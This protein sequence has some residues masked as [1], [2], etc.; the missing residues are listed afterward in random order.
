MNNKN[1]KS[2]INATLVALV[3]S[4][5]TLALADDT[6]VFLARSS[7]PNLLFV[8]DMS[9]SMRWGIQARGYNPRTGEIDEGKPPSRSDVMKNAMKRVLNQAPDEINIGLMSYGP[10]NFDGS[11]SRIDWPE[12][13]R[14]HGVHGVGFPIKGI[15]E[16][17]L[18]IVS[19][20]L[21]IDNLPDPSNKTIVRKYLSEIIKSWEPKGST[22]IVDSLVEA[23]RYFAGDKVFFG[24][25]IP[26]SQR[27]AHPLTYAGEVITSDLVTT[28]RKLSNAPNYKS[29]ITDGCQENYIAL[30][31][32][33][34]P[35]YFYS[36]Q[37]E[38]IREKG[39]PFVV[40]KENWGKG[41]GPFADY[42]R[43]N[44]NYGTLA[45]SI[46]DCAD[47][48]SGFRAGTCGPEIARYMA[49]GDM[50]DEVSGKQTI[51]MFTVGYT[52][53]VDR[54]TQEYLKSLVTVEDNPKTPWREGYY[55]ADNAQKLKKALF[56][57]VNRVANSASTLGSPSYSVNV[58]NGLEHEDEIYIP[59]FSKASGVRWSGNLKKFGLVNTSQGGYE[60]KKIKGKN[61]LE[62][63]DEQGRFTEDALDYWSNSPTESPD[64][65]NLRAGGVAGKLNPASRKLF[66][67]IVC[68]PGSCELNSESNLLDTKNEKITSE[69]LGLKGN[70]NNKGNKKG[71]TDFDDIDRE[72]LIN[73]IRGE[74]PDN[75]I[76]YHMGDM[77][78]SDPLV[79]TYASAGNDIAKKQYIFVGTNEGYLHAFDTTTGEEK[80]AFMPKELLENIL[81][82]YLNVDGNHLY[83]IDGA[84]SHWQDKVTKKR[85]LY[86]GM[87]RGGT[88]FYALDITDIDNPRLLWKKSAIDYPSMG[89]SWS[90]PYLD[91]I[92][93]G[94][95]GDKR[96]AVIISGGYDDIEDRNN[97]KGLL[98]LDNASKD[99]KTRVGKDILIL[100]A[101]TGEKLWSL[102]DSLGNSDITDSIP[103]GIRVLDTNNNNIADRM[104]FADTGG[105][106]WRLD[107][108]EALGSRDGKS[109]LTKLASL[110]GSGSNSR[111]FYIEPEVASVK[112]RGKLLYVVSVGSG[113]RAHPLNQSI[114]DKFFMLVDDLPFQPVDENF[115]TIQTADLAQINITGDDAGDTSLSTNGS[116][117]DEGKRGWMIS[118]PQKGEKVLTKAITRN[119]SVI[120]TTFVPETDEASCGIANG[121]V[122]RLYAINVVTGKAGINFKELQSRKTL[123]KT[124]EASEE[125]SPRLPGPGYPG[126]V[127]PPE[128]VFGS[129][130]VDA[131]GVCKHP[132]DYR[133]G[134]KSS[135]VSGYSACSLEPAYWSDPEIN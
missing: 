125:W 27:G 8:I 74:N 47:S 85:Y 67:D 19:D 106:V 40:S 110:G 75:T 92:G 120:F 44:K 128:V 29:P 121:S 113:F 9:D 105:N 54:S 35:A 53:S 52:R 37:T 31:S 16:L 131:K 10:G 11:E 12:N 59:I 65:S 7:K 33:G 69:M 60:V 130:E 134:R 132:V 61:N 101:K 124:S 77:L 55:S 42:M 48:P 68:E 21:K 116:F 73:F 82:Q 118:F 102:K 114:D 3:L 96:E 17:A 98:K 13:S 36:D 5:Q 112:H 25:D 71:D 57:I 30:L 104:Y 107:L 24:Q 108:S 39:K 103:G 22:P 64:G 63:F 95:I 46:K 81:P 84:I 23:S 123:E 126:I 38:T 115:T 18:P 26:S 6:E 78:H 2:V 79:V 91:R 83:G 127:P 86:F 129:F 49:S 62:A 43:G 119:G 4:I 45:E 97:S 109:K 72:L 76:R 135:P 34:E 99:V 66:S 90:A 89:Q 15:N 50:N 94:E 122:S 20:Y 51:K 87:R 117:Y 14:S 32:D 133:L 28:P 58:L 41:L 80:F 111:K 56:D 93:F 88:S 70:G 1:F 100:D